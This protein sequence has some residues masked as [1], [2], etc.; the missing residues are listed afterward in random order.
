MQIDSAARVHVETMLSSN[1]VYSLL[2]SSSVVW[3]ARRR[4]VDRAWV[5]HHALC[6]STSSNYCQTLDHTAPRSVHTAAHFVTPDN[7]LLL[8]H[9]AQSK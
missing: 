8:K 2:T 9:R 7:A 6:L 3:L 5:V 4:A 1:V